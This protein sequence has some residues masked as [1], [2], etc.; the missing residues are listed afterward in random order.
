MKKP[1]GSIYETLNVLIAQ[2]DGVPDQTLAAW[3]LP[4][5]A[6]LR[7]SA[8]PA[9]DVPARVIALAHLVGIDLA[10]VG[11]HGHAPEEV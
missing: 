7:E 4:I 8:E 10:N 5:F 3:L 9:G 2:L 1:N 6:R 11:A